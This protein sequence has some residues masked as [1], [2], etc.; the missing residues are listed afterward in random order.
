[1]KAIYRTTLNF[2]K[3][4]WEAMKVFAKTVWEG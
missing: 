3:G 4:F 2:F 1:M